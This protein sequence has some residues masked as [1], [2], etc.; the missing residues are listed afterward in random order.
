MGICWSTLLESSKEQRGFGGHGGGEENQKYDGTDKITFRYV[1]VLIIFLWKRYLLTVGLF[2]K[3]SGP[4]FLQYYDW[5]YLIS[6]EHDRTGQFSMAH[7][8]RRLHILNF[9]SQILWIHIMMAEK[10]VRL[11]NL[12]NHEKSACFML[13]VFFFQHHR[14]HFYRQQS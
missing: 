9:L 6:R 4:I 14:N 7:F 11:V 13:C 8:S 10:M 2:F 3:P 1:G 5:G 12:F